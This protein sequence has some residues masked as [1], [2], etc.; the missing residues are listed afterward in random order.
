[1]R[2]VNILLMGREARC[3]ISFMK[4]KKKLTN[5]FGEYGGFCHSTV[6]STARM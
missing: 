6:G 5:C 4:K 3:E 1:M 2:L